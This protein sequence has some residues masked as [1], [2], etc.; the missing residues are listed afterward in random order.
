[1][2]AVEFVAQVAPGV[3][4]AG[5]GDADEQQCQPT[6]LD[7]SADA[8]LAVVVDP[9]RNPRLVLQSRQPRSTASSC[10]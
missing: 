8:V 6:Q 3:A 9:G 7:V 2:H 4:G 1:M 10:L 5:F